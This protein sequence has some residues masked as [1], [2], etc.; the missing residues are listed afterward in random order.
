[1]RKTSYRMVPQRTAATTTT[2]R[3]SWNT[4]QQVEQWQ[5][6]NAANLA[7]QTRD[8]GSGYEKHAIAISS[9]FV[10]SNALFNEIKWQQY[11]IKR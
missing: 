4:Y 8:P 9:T 5:Q 3:H 7:E 11:E 1:M 10:L 2:L 6:L